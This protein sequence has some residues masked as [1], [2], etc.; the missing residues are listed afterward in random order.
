MN[1][2]SK[3]RAQW[4][5]L[6]LGILQG[7]GIDIGCG[8]DPVTPDVRPFDLEHGDANV[9]SRHVADTFDFVFSAHCLEHM[10]SPSAALREW[11]KLVRPGGYLFFIVP[12]ENLFEQQMWPS[13][14]NSDH[15]ATF[16]TSRDASWSPVSI[17][18]FA[19][20]AELPGAE[21]LD[22]RVHDDGYDRTCLL[23]RPGARFRTRVLFS[24]RWRLVALLRRVGIRA[25][26]LW[27]AHVFRVPID[28]TVSGALA[29]I[30]VIVR[31]SAA[32]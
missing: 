25:R 7:K 23:N 14:F 32:G 5:A 6:E 9:I 22:V 8:P 21:L 4:G 18:I 26:L 2:A 30:Q 12:E 15:K 29:Q 16:T 11:W 24:I 13:V 31:K 10:H 28:Q 1:E 20:V 17:N 27:I 19:L 3:T